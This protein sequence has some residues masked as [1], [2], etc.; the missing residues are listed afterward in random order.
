MSFTKKLGGIA[1]GLTLAL[2]MTPASADTWMG[3]SYIPH[4]NIAP[5]AGFVR[6]A[7]RLNAET[8][9]AI[10]AVPRLG[11]ELPIKGPNIVQAVSDNIVQWGLTGFFAGDVPLASITR[12]PMLAGS[13]EEFDKIM[14]IAGDDIRAEFDKIGVYAIGYHTW[15]P[16]TIFTKDEI[17]NLHDLEGFKIRDGGPESKILLSSYG[18]SPITM[19]TADVAPALQQGVIDGVVTASGGGGKLWKDQL[20]Y[21]LRVQMYIPDGW[22]VVNKDVWEGL[23]PEIQAKVQRIFDEEMSAISEATVNDEGVAMQEQ[24]DGGMTIIMPSD[25]MVAEAKARVE[26]QWGEW[27]EATGPRAVELVAEIRAALGK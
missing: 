20:G 4:T 13:Q 8:D 6:I 23:S 25:E 12:L 27:A 26:A 17:A 1:V 22:F 7:E 5:G 9:G 19:A 14:E 2:S 11:G 24:K 16:V 18:A 10:T 15:G 3:Y 21:N